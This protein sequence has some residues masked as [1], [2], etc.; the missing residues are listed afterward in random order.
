MSRDP[1]FIECPWCDGQGGADVFTGIDPRD[2]SDQGYYERCEHCDG[3]GTVE[4]EALLLEEVDLD[5]AWPADH[6]VA[7]AI[8]TL[9]ALPIFI[10]LLDVLPT[11]PIPQ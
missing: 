10:G 6:F 3:T 8:A 9:I 2:G 1:R 7:G 4:G 11:T 5:E